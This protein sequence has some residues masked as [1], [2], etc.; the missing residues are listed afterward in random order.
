M[1]KTL[2]QIGDPRENEQ[3]AD[4]DDARQRGHNSIEKGKHAKQ[5]EGGPDAD[6]PVWFQLGRKGWQARNTTSRKA[7]ACEDPA[8]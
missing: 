4:N 8:R 3:H 6:E 7:P 5:D 2:R 1:G